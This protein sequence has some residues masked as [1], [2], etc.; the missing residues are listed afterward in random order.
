MVCGE[1]CQESGDTARVSLENILDREFFSLM[2]SSR[3]SVKLLY[4]LVFP[5]SLVNFFC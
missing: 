5:Y 2:S 4:S 1:V 3:D